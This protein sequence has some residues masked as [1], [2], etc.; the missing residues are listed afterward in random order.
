MTNIHT[1]LIDHSEVSV[2]LDSLVT[3]L[4]NQLNDKDYVQAFATI[5]EMRNATSELKNWLMIEISKEKS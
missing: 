1:N 4:H 5:V 3:K 2:M